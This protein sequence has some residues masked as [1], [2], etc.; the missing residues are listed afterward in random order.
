MLNTEIKPVL[1]F[2]STVYKA[3]KFNLFYFI[4]FFIE[5]VFF[6][7]KGS[8][9]LNEKRKG[10]LTTLAVVI[11]K[12]P[13]TSIRKHA[14]EK[15]GRTAIKQDLSSDHKPLDYAMLGVLE[16][17]TNVTSHPNIGLL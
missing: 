17:K 12:D 1:F 11:K 15:T 10:F 5:K 8:G 9:G 13:S 16:N 3:K 4:F 14:N 7:E 6:K 2:L